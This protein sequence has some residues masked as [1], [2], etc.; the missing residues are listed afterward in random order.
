MTEELSPQAQEIEALDRIARTPDGAMLHRYLRRVLESVRVTEDIGALQRQ[1]GA[2]M[3]AKD[4]MRHMAQ[5]VEA[6]S[7]RTEPILSSAASPAG[8][9]GRAFRGNARRVA[10]DPSVTTFLD[11]PD[12]FQTA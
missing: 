8:A 6:N 5:A 7:G 9:P 10:V 1:E 3:F 12:G 2:R 4:L 11:E